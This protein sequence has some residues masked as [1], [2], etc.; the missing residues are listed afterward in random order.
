MPKRWKPRNR[1]SSTLKDRRVPSIKAWGCSSSSNNKPSKIL[2]PNCWPSSNP[3]LRTAR[4]QS[5]RIRKPSKN[6]RYSRSISCKETSPRQRKRS[7]LRQSSRSNQKETISTKNIGKNTN[8]STSKPVAGKG[9]IILRRED[10]DV[11]QENECRFLGLH[12]SANG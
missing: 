11:E 6:S 1:S 2:N 3:P 5:N 8:K 7:L 4:R 10:G 9:Q 12:A